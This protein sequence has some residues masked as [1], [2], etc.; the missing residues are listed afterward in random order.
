[1]KEY[2]IENGRVVVVD[3]D[4]ERELISL[5]GNWENVATEIGRV[6]LADCLGQQVAAD[7]E[8]LSRFVDGPVSAMA[9]ADLFILRESQIREWRRQHEM[10]R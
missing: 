7:D 2:R 5:S 4:A 10:F 9:G 6:I 8:Y 3:G 1:M